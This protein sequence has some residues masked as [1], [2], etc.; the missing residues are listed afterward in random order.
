MSKKQPSADQIELLK[1]FNNTSAAFPSEKCLPQLFEEQCNLTPNSIAVRF[2][3]KT[4][5]YSELNKKA[6]QLGHYLRKNGIGSDSMVGL[7]A[8]RSFELVIGVLGILKAGAAYV[9]FDASYPSERIEYM[10][11]DSKIKIVLV[12][13]ALATIFQNKELQILSLDK[14]WEKISKEN[15]ENPSHVNK[16]LNLAYV[17]FTSGSTGKPKGVGM[18][19]RALMNLIH[20]QK[21]KTNLGVVAKTLQ[22]APISFDVSFQ[23][24]FT[25]WTTGGTLVLIEDD[26]RLNAIKLL[27][28]INTEKIERL[29][30]PFIALQHLAEVADEN[31]IFPNSLK[32]VITAGEQ[33]Q[34]TKH[35]AN[36][37]TALPNCKLHNHYGPTESH[38]CTAYTLEGKP[39]KWIALPSI[40]TPISNTQI[41][42]LDENFN[43]VKVGEEGELCI[44]GIALARGYINRDD[45]TAERFLENPFGEER[46]YKTGDLAKYLPDG[47]IEYLGRIDGQVKVRGYRIELGEIEIALGKNAD[48]NQCVVIA[49]EDEPGDKRLVAYIIP[50]EKNNF[51]QNELRKFLKDKLPD[52]MMPSAFVQMEVFPRTPSGK[53][54]KRSLPKPEL[55]RPELD[56]IFVEAQTDLEKTFAKIWS[57]F[58]RIDKVGINDNFF[59]LGGNSLMALQM[60]AKLK[61]ENGIDLPVVKLYQHPTI[62]TIVKMFSNDNKEQSFY[63]KA[64][65][66]I[67]ATDSQINNKNKNVEDGIAIIGMAGRFPGAKNTDELW[68]NLIEGKE[69]TKFFTKGELDAA[70]P[71]DVKNDSSYVPARGVIDDAD[72]FDAAFFGVNPKLA[73]LMDPQQRIFLEVAWESLENAGY[74]SENF[75][76]MIGVFAG[77]GN[78]TYFMNNVISRKELIER[79]GSFS[80]MT[81]NEKDY[82][83]TRI[84][85]EMNLTGPALSIHT[86]CSTS[87]VAIAVAFENLINNKC[88]MAIA[89]GISI[90]SPINSGH[91][92]N[93]G[94]M[95]SS[96]GHTRTFDAN[97]TGTVFSDGCGIVVLKRYKDAV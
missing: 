82:I 93:E 37:F 71:P 30:L 96:D 84:S 25:T 89:G 87:L 52:Y 23:E 72:K 66:R 21:T 64:K 42:L 80:V 88:D 5:T 7:C 90:T 48:V 17:L 46:I 33:L 14:E 31:K 95:F 15:L 67:V 19:H 41:Y 81:A 28:F 53:I 70:I 60:I 55:K 86:A 54:D 16:P 20:W 18:I 83:A 69:T 10:L 26:F 91:I 65:Q 79:V 59:D 1:K 63:E 40:G 50:N 43:P 78:N 27:E 97:A 2:Y 4:L 77:M 6:N 92:Y 85:H 35:I 3:D 24:L 34:I 47:N 75:K 58:L 29:F 44:G 36:F 39:D 22:F 12:Q 11:K 62:S 49:R 73:E 56:S 51:H 74:S 9:P 76:G 38:V 32:D 45:L 61:M 13:D 8:E 57:K 68:K 94:G